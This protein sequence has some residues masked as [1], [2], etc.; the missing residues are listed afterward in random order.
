ME[1]LKLIPYTKGKHLIKLIPYTKVMDT[2]DK[3]LSETDPTIPIPGPRVDSMISFA[4]GSQ[5]I[6]TLHA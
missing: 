6:D 4:S 2:T 1:L 3:I 5:V